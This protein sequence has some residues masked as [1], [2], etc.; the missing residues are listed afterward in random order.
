[1]NKEDLNKRI[2]AGNFKEN[3]GRILRTI[4]ILSGKDIKL[5]SIEFALSE[6]KNHELYESLFYL[7]DSGYIKIRNINSKI[8]IDI[9]D[10]DPDDTEIRITRKGMELLKGFDNN[11][12]VDV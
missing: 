11:P 3:N 8:D 12:A 4:N 9:Y 2:E 7:Q 10:A 5:K 6:I 1:V